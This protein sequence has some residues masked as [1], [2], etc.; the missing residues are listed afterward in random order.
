LNVHPLIFDPIFKPRVWGGR[1]LESLLSKKLPPDEPIG[2]S[3][4]IA[5][6]EGN[7][8]LV[9][10]G[11]ARGQSIRRLINDWG[12]D[13]YGRAALHHERFPLLIKFLDAAAALSVQV[14]PSE[15]SDDAVVARA[16][17]EAWYI[18]DAPPDG[19]LYRGLQDGVDSTSLRQAV[20]SGRIE[21]VLRR[22]PARKGHAYFVPGGMVHALGPGIVVAEIQTP[23]DTTFRLFDWNR[24]DPKTGRPRERHLDEALRCVD[25]TVRAFPEERKEHLGSVWTSV[26]TLIR[27]DSFV[28]ERVRMVEGV[29]QE[30]P[31]DEMVIWIVLQGRGTIHHAGTWAAADFGAGDTVLLPAGLKQARVQTHDRCLWLEVTVPIPSPLK[32]LPRPQPKDLEEPE[33]QSRLVPLNVS[34]KIPP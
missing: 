29:Q 20:E 22:V 31:Y 3:W 8:S 26:T 14:H 10:H 2:E 19:Y 13:L 25:T 1:S 27:C 15:D 17:Q 32:G 24:I 28:V 16:K 9:A 33:S 4:E 7:E 5:D 18:L 11:P 12:T 21:T 6:L 30:I 23:S 34:R